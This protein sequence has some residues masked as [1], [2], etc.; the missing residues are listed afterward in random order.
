MT[1]EERINASATVLLAKKL[2]EEYHRGRHEATG[3]RRMDVF[4]RR[5]SETWHTYIPRAVHVVELATSADSDGSAALLWLAE[6]SCGDYYHGCHEGVGD[7][8]NDVYQQKVKDYWHRWVPKSRELLIE[9]F[10]HLAEKLK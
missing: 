1:P 10:P 6:A 4:D 7:R 9:A 3:D 8:R 2:C 5:V